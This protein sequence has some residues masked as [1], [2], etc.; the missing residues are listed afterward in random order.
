MDFSVIKEVIKP[1][2]DI[3]DHKYMNDIDGLDNPTCENI[4]KWLWEG[5]KPDIPLLKRIQLDE[6]PTSGAIYEGG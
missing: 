2:I 3:V 6:T 4:A 5:I 1:L